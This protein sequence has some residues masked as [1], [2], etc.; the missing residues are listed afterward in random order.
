MRKFIH[1]LIIFS[2]MISSALANVTVYRCLEGGDL[3]L[4]KTCCLE[5]EAVSTCCSDH[6]SKIIVNDECCDE[7]EIV[8]DTIS[9]YFSTKEIKTADF[10]NDLEKF[11][12][13]SLTAKTLV[14]TDTIR[15][16]PISDTANHQYRSP[17]YIQHC[18]Y[19]C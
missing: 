14:F 18:S 7:V 9:P 11:I 15:G 12:T 17:L 6:A 8:Q 13:D 19:L 5:L 10:S 2:L 1:T 4:T 3:C 16:P